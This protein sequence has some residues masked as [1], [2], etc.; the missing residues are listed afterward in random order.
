MTKPLSA[1]DFAALETIRRVMRR[2]PRARG[3]SV[4][5]IDTRRGGV[6]WARRIASFL[7]GLLA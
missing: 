2:G 6:V 1:A 7:R 4:G 5:F 3:L